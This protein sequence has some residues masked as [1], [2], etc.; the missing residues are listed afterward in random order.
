[1]S[2]ACR[3][4]VPLIPCVLV[5]PV[6]LFVVCALVVRVILRSAVVSSVLPQLFSPPWSLS[7][8]TLQ[9]RRARLSFPCAEDLIWHDGH[10]E[11]EEEGAPDG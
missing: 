6:C 8:F 9:L 1:M 11:E 4:V 10:E 5:S 3:S 2:L 7:S